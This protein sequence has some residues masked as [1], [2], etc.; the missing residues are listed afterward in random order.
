MFSRVLGS[1][2]L[3]RFA[4]WEKYQIDRLRMS[5]PQIFFFG[6]RWFLGGYWK[7]FSDGCIS[8]PFSRK[9]TMYFLR[10]A[11][12][13]VERYLVETRFVERILSKVFR[14][15]AFGRKTF[16]RKIF[17][18]KTFCRKAFCRKDLTTLLLPFQHEF[19]FRIIPGM[20]QDFRAP[21]LWLCPLLDKMLFDENL[22][23]NSLSTKNIRPKT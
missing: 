7:I 9:S 14:R 11:M 6:E 18:R 19:R 23:T 8:A 4:S 15:K 13:F 21:T 20:S 16:C 22:S 10:N 17:C 1:V 2:H 12:F 5:H 3:V